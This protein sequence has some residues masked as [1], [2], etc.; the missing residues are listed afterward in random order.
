MVTTAFINIYGQRV[1]AVAWD[2]DTEVASFEYDQ[3]F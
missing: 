3:T 1:G 2:P